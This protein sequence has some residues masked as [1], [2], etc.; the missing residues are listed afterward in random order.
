MGS[1]PTTKDTDV[2]YHGTLGPLGSSSPKTEP[3]PISLSLDSVINGYVRDS[4][5]KVKITEGYDFDHFDTINKIE[6]Y[7]AS[8][9]KSGDSDSLGNKK[10]FMNIVN[11]PAGNVTKNVDLDTADI[12]IRADDGTNAFK[13]ELYREKLKEWLEENRIGILLNR[14][15]ENLPIYGQVVLKNLKDK[16]IEFTPLRY[17]YRDPGILGLQ[18]SMYVI[19]HHRL[20]PQALKKK[21]ADGWYEDGIKKVIAAFFRSGDKQINVHEFY[22]WVQGL[23]V[24]QFADF[25]GVEDDEYVKVR[26][27]VAMNVNDATPDRK[28]TN[29]FNEVLHVIKWTDEDWPY[30]ELNLFD[31]EGRGLGLGIFEMLF[32]LQQR[33]NEMGNCKA[34]SMRIS[35]KQIFQTRGNT[36]EK[37]VLTDI[38]SGT[39]LSNGGSEITPIAT[40]ERNLS[41]YQQEENNI[42]E[43]AREIAN[44]QEVASGGDLPSGTPYRLGVLMSQNASKLHEFIREKFGLFLEDILKR[45]LIPVFE[46]EIVAGFNLEIRTPELLQRVIEEDIN[47]RLNET[48]KKYFLAYGDF[49]RPDELEMFKA[50]MRKEYAGK[51]FVKIPP[52]YFEFTKD[53]KVIITGENSNLKQQIE[54]IS[55]LIQLLSQNPGV[56]DNPATQ[57]LFGALL[58]KVGISPTLLP[59]AGA[60][61]PAEMPAM[62]QLGNGAGQAGMEGAISA[63]TQGVKTGAPAGMGAPAGPMPFAVPA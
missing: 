3:E 63:G 43:L 36:I 7:R 5:E 18:N 51:Q 10:Y 11:A 22:G 2:P 6:L 53:L 12:T 20:Q 14:I 50:T 37:N 19:Q 23:M 21:V 49:P 47:Q 46:K 4:K 62:N 8:K 26:G 35:S 13:A 61:A 44:N 30:A 34:T 56:L 40:E 54:S 57:K 17:L 27:F 28:E 52:K 31:I 16:K 9:F 41:T 48:I 59:M 32:D 25:D 38:E 24:K 33:R 58:E 55:N 29:S 45:W 15:S 42:R 39:I 60:K 1:D